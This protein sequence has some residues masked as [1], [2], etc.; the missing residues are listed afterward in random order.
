MKYAQYGT[1]QEHFLQICVEWFGF[2][3]LHMNIYIIFQN[4]ISFCIFRGPVLWSDF[5]PG[6]GMVSVPIRVW[7]SRSVD[8][9]TGSDFVTLV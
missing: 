4:L 2:T 3:W 7:F 9:T 1:Y 5:F 6:F 8:S